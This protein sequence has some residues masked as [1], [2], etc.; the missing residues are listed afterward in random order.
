[1]YLMQGHADLLTKTRYILSINQWIKS[2]RLE[3]SLILPNHCVR[4]I[5]TAIT[6]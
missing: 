5:F 2:V 1:M 3:V 4:N 6:V